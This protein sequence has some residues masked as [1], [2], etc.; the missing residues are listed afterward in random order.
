MVYGCDAPIFSNDFDDDVPGP[1]VDVAD[2][3]D[4]P[5]NSGVDEGRVEIVEGADAFAGR[6]LRIH[7]PEG[8]VGPGEGGAQWKAALGDDY[9]ELYLAYRVRFAPRLR[10]C[11]R[12]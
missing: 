1:Y 7:Y 5:P 6:P 3:N 10:L 12:R 11:A 2:W 8:G 4:P 9:D